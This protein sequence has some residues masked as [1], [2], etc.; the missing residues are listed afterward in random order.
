MTHSDAD[1][2]AA[3]CESCGLC[4]DGSLFGLVRLA[5]EEKTARHRL[6]IVNDGFEQPCSAHTKTGCAIY[7]ER[8]AACRNFECRMRDRHR[9]EGGPLEPR[10]AVVTRVRELIRILQERGRSAFDLDEESSIEHAELTRLLEDH[11]SRA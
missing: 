1:V 7:D 2:L 10:V 6:R 4:C 3:L 11:F 8:P 9:R 5:P